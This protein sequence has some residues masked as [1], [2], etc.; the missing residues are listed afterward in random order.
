MKFNIGAAFG[1]FATTLSE[2]IAEEEKRVDLL[3]DKALDL[4][5]RLMLDEKERNRTNIEN[6]EK[7]I[8]ALNVTGLDLET[9]TAIA[10]G[11]EIAVNQALS[12][13]DIATKKGVDFST[14][15]NVTAPTP[16]TED[17]TATDWAS[18]IVAPMQE[19]EIATGVMGESHTIFGPDP[20]AEFKRKLKV[21]GAGD[22]DKAVSKVFQP[23]ELE[24]DLSQLSEAADLYTSTEQA[25]VGTT[26]LL[27]RE[28]N[29]PESEQDADKIKQL[30]ADLVAYSILDEDDGDPQKIADRI[31]RFGIQLAELNIVPESERDEAWK[32]NYDTTKMTLDSLIN[33]ANNIKTA[34]DLSTEKFATHNAMLVSIDQQLMNATGVEKTK[35]EEQRK[36]LFQQILDDKKALAAAEG[37]NPDDYTIFSNQSVDSILNNAFKRSLE[38]QGFEYG[39]EGQLLTKLKGNEA[40]YIIGSFE[41]INSVETRYKDVS[42]VVLLNALTAE[43]ERV[44]N[45]LDRYKNKKF[46]EY[47]TNTQEGKDTKGFYIENDINVIEKNINNGVYKIGDMIQTK[48]SNNNTRIVMFDG[49][50]LL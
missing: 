14:V 18:Q 22:V 3:T 25:L 28:R 24:V 29:K 31:D 2:R 49:K 7:L 47:L 44:T 21:I 42:D 16:G 33:V 34:Q 1:G 4:H 30:E 38:P 50:G 37:G 10:Q 46:N 35:L 20:Q 17:F 12:Q 41:A 32:Q 13:F 8:N 9:R 39:L 43:K 48:D 5:T 40:R 15:Y 36:T 11:G 19:P 45:V 26:Q 23:A 6:A 27:Q